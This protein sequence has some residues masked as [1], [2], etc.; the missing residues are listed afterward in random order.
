MLLAIDT[1]TRNASLAL[2]DA[3]GVLAERSWRSAN[4][5]SVEML[6]AIAEMVSLQGCT[7]ADL[8]AVA[9]A[10]GPGSFTGLR[11]G[12]SIAKGLCLALSIP[13]IAVPTLDIITYAVGDPGGEV[14]AVLE[15]GR[16]RVYVQ[17]Y[18]F[19]DGYPVADGPIEV[20][21]AADW[22]PG[23]TEP[24]L[25]AGEV[26]AELAK[27]LLQQDETDSLSIASLAGSVRRAGYLAELA[28]DRFVRDEA[29]DL[30]SLVPAYV[31]YPTT[32]TG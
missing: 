31:R 13:I 28:W 5:H 27:H 15:A 2:Y 17:R 20:Q 1:A 25:V 19:E 26:S 11:I 8:T 10:Q 23:N 3:T 9:V 4:N 12:M 16:G 22:V 30:D 24:A 14:F 6:P 32:S 21:H 18:R 7:P 29:D